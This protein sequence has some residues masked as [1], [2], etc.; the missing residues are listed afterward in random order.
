MIPQG[1]K[2]RQ[3]EIKISTNLNSALLSGNYDGLLVSSPLG[4]SPLGI[5]RMELET[6]D[7]ETLN[8]LDTNCR[9]FDSSDNFI[10]AGFE[11]N[12]QKK[13]L[14]A[15]N[16][17]SNYYNSNSP[18]T[19]TIW[20]DFLYA[21]TYYSLVLA[22]HMKIRKLGF[23]H[24]F[25]RI[26]KRFI[27]CIGDAIGLYTDNFNQNTIEEIIFTGCCFN[28]NQETELSQLFD[29]NHEGAITT[30]RE[31]QHERYDFANMT[32]IDIKLGSN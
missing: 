15:P 6:N 21:S 10:L 22:S 20:L 1:V 28:E 18:T 17:N 13:L 4:Y 31:I 32:C 26:D 9:N 11:L 27:Y 19:G 7:Q 8:R 23:T 2:G 16:Q 24:T 14:L 25:N 29:L 12:Q 3:S 5:L 30:H